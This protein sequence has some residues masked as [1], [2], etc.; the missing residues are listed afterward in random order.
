ML[1]PPLL[2]I[3]NNTLLKKNIRILFIFLESPHEA[4]SSIFRWSLATFP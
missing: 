1:S 2:D 3:I 4:P